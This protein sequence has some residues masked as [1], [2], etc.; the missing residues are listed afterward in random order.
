[1]FDTLNS[2]KQN[3]ITGKIISKD[4]STMC[5]IL[6]DKG[7]K[8]SAESDGS[9]TVGQTVLVKDGIVIGKTKKIKTVQQF[10]V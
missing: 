7:R 4:T 6:D 3:V 2:K 1:M 8:F 5:S 9:F 10:N